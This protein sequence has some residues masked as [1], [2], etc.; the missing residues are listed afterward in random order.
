MRNLIAAL[1]M[2]SI[3]GCRHDGSS[4]ESS[5]LLGKWIT[6]SCEQ[7]DITGLGGNTTTIWVKGIYEFLSNG[8]IIVS[9]RDYDDSSCSGEFTLVEPIAESGQ[10]LAFNDL[11]KETLEDGVEGGRVEIT[12]PT[13]ESITVVGFYAQNNG[14]LCFSD[15]LNFDAFSWSSSGAEYTS[16]DY[17]KCLTELV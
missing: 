14:S 8:Q 2:M 13:E 9:F 5:S 10:F 11:G 12:I 7:N 1:L 15:N 4:Q 17:E 16:I 6:D 3:L